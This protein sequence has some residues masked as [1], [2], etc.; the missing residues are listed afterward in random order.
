MDYVLDVIFGVLLELT[1]QLKP[2]CKLK[3]WQEVILIILSVLL[4]LS[5]IGCLIA[6]VHILSAVPGYKT[7][8]KILL[9]V[10]ICLIVLQ[11]VTYAVLIGKHLKTQRD[12]PPK[13]DE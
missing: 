10:G 9:A 7:V 8:G 11:C 4:L 13:S 6:G 5:S 1:K 12:T 3:K 2:N